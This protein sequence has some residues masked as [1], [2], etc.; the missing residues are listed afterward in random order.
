MYVKH[1]DRCE[2]NLPLLRS[3]ISLATSTLK[4]EQA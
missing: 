2:N 3:H 4:Q 1:L